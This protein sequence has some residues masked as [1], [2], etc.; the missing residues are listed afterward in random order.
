MGH[1][2]AP[3]EAVLTRL[4]PGALQQ[5]RRGFRIDSRLVYAALVA[6]GM[7]LALWRALS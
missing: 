5:V 6:G 2:R 7:A 1:W 4:Q 3:R